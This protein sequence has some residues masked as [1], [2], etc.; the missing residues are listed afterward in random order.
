MPVSKGGADGLAISFAEGTGLRLSPLGEGDSDVKGYGLY[1][2]KWSAPFNLEETDGKLNVA[3]DMPSNR[4]EIPGK[5]S[6]GVCTVSEAAAESLRDNIELPTV[7]GYALTVSEECIDE[8][9]VTFKA[10]YCRRGL[11]V[12]VK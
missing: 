8:G 6:F 4:S 11:S 5:F 12:I 2:V 9:T 7:R 10:S 1:N 3:L